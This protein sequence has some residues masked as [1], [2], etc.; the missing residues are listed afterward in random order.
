MLRVV[1]L[2]KRAV[3]IIGGLVVA[4]GAVWVIGFRWGFTPL[5]EPPHGVRIE[6]LLPPL[7]R[8]DLKPDNAA[9][10]YMKASDLLDSYAQSKNSKAKKESSGQ[11]EALLAGELPGDTK[12]IEHTLT[13]CREALDLGRAASDMSF[14]QMPLMTEGS[15]FIGRLRQLARLLVADGKLAQKNGD[16]DRAITNYLAVVKLGTDCSKG[17]ATLQSLVGTAIADMGTRAVRAWILQAA[18]TREATERIIKSL[19]RNDHD[20]TP[21]A[22]T[23]RNELKYA[24]KESSQQILKESGPWGRL[25][26][27]K[28]VTNRYFDAALGDLI[29][30]SDKPFWQSDTKHVVEKW[31]P[32]GRQMWLG[33]PNRPM[34][35]NL[36]A[37]TLAAISGTRKKVIQAE[38][39]LTASEVVCALKAYEL[40]HDKPPEQLADLVPDFLP[41]I[42][43]DPFDGK[44]LRYR[45]EGKEWVIWSVGSD[46]KDDKAAWHEFKYQTPDEERKGGDI[47]FKSTEPQDDLADHLKRKGSQ[48][49]S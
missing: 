43:I 22:E 38:L 28:R 10:Y 39:N 29:Q 26:Y 30:E 1:R 4:Y 6:P 21:Y 27:S 31:D 42:P 9:F 20:R 40:T 37:M 44:P 41:S 5:P 19:T 11:L 46:L 34:Q 17:G 2:V 18:T 8:N 12:A 47:Y 14:C 45:R 33:A 15:T 32:E 49:R 13:D 25:L 35:R 23:L 16:S 24:K 36:M 48:K 3:L 7:A